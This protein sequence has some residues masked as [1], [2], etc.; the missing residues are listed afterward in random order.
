VIF[1]MKPRGGARNSMR[2]IAMGLCGVMALAVFVWLAGC[3]GDDSG[4]TNPSPTTGLVMKLEWASA[5]DLDLSATTPN[6][7]VSAKAAAPDPN[8][9]HS[10][11]NT[12]TGTG[13]FSETISCSDPDFGNYDIAVANQSGGPIDYTLSVAIDEESQSGFPVSQ[14]VGAGAQADHSVTYSPP[15]DTLPCPYCSDRPDNLAVRIHIL[16]VHSVPDVVVTVDNVNDSTAPCKMYYCGGDSSCVS[17]EFGSRCYD[18]DIR[19]VPCNDRCEP[20]IF[21]LD[22]RPGEFGQAWVY[23]AAG[24]TIA[25]AF[26]VPQYGATYFFRCVLADDI[27][28]THGGQAFASFYISPAQILVCEAGWQGPAAKP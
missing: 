1:P 3:G 20:K 4:P 8:C 22:Y 23:A 27:H 13:P 11:D 28:T 24:D 14:S 18:G 5:G 7:T 15:A 25:F 17:D 16:N 19:Y 2:T 21:A 9:A 26:R 10:G 6:G 12:G